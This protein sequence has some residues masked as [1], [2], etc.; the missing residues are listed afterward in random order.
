[1]HKELLHR[2]F[3]TYGIIPLIVITLSVSNL[4]LPVKKDSK[5]VKIYFFKH[6][7]A[8]FT[9]GATVTQ[10]LQHACLAVMCTKSHK[11]GDFFFLNRPELTD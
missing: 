1:M 3:L 2:I 5:N 4:L 8:T 11:D 6:L 7:P 9:M 10:R